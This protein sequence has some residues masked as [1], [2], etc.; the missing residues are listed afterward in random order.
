MQIGLR[1]LPEFVAL[2]KSADSGKNA[3]VFTDWH[4]RSLTR[5]SIGRISKK[6]SLNQAYAPAHLLKERLY[7]I[8][9]YLAIIVYTAFLGKVYLGALLDWRKL[10]FDSR[11]VYQY[12]LCCRRCRIILIGLVVRVGKTVEDR[13]KSRI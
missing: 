2:V 3:P 5:L 7:R 11:K 8:G 12:N 9:Y 6:G 4:R 1:A 10:K 13:G